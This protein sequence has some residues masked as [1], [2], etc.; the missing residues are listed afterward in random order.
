MEENKG[1]YPKFFFPILYIFLASFILSVH[2][3]LQTTMFELI[4]LFL[5]QSVEY[6]WY[7]VLYIAIKFLVLTLNICKSYFVQL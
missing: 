7:K 1:K 4:V 2:Q 6:G 3:A 5:C